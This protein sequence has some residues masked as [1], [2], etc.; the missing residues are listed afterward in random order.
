MIKIF[1]VFLVFIFLWSNSAYSQQW[2]FTEVI[3]VSQHPPGHYFHHLESSGRRNIAVSND[4]VAVT[5]E[6]DR[7]NTARIYLALK[8]PEEKNF[9]SEI[10]LSGNDDAFEP[11]ITNLTKNHFAISWEENQTIHVRIVDASSLKN[12]RL[13]SIF[14]VKQSVGGQ[15]NIVSENNRLFIVY[16]H[17]KRSFPQIALTV[18]DFDRLQIKSARY[19]L[20]EPQAIKTEQ[21]YPVAQIVKDNL[22]VAW[23]DRRHGHSVILSSKS[24]L[25]SPCQFSE[26]QRISQNFPLPDTP[27]GKGSGVARVALASFDK[28]QLMAVWADKRN[29]SEGYDIYSAS[30]ENLKNWS[31]NR[32][33]Q[34]EFGG[35]A[36]QWHASIAGHSKGQLIAA[37][38]DEREGTGDIFYSSLFQGSWSEDRP[39]PGASGDGEQNHPSIT[40][41]SR[42]NIHLVWIERSEVGS[43]TQ[44]YYTSAYQTN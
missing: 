9:T 6:D 10:Q 20:I 13:S 8:K 15:A 41:D 42:G 21:F 23:E 29:F 3:S 14:T 18:L 26:P 2:Q 22:I 11:T 25:A 34:D 7:D 44:L 43:T 27:Y 39:V 19:C 31:D 28:S 35:V 37:W 32:P 1:T 17:Q 40:M 30:Y 33:V 4:I 24:H 5:W 12:V 16:S 38:T 36:R